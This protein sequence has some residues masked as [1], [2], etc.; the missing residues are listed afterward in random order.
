MPRFSDYQ[1][2]ARD[3]EGEAVRRYTNNAYDRFD[4]IPQAKVEAILRQEARGGAISKQLVDRLIQDE[5]KAVDNAVK[6]VRREYGYSVGQGAV[7]DFY[8]RFYNVMSRKFKDAAYKLAGV[9]MGLGEENMRY[10][11]P[12]WGYRGV[13]FAS[14]PDLK[15]AVDMTNAAYERIKKVSSALNDAR[16]YLKDYGDKHPGSFNGKIGELFYAFADVQ[17]ATFKLIGEIGKLNR[18]SKQI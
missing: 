7:S 1:L 2:T 15:K 10:Y 14:D 6:D 13:R 3:V 17:S 12:R 11:Q 9:R 5:K 8:K 16:L 4:D 18:I